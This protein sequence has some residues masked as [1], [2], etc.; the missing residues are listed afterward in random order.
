MFASERRGGSAGVRARA[1]PGERALAAGSVP[2]ARLARTGLAVA[3]AALVLQS[4]AHLVN[5]L[6][7]D[8]RFR[9][10]NADVDGNLLSWVSALATF[11]AASAAL[12]LAA[13]VPPRRRRLVALAAI[14]A[15]FSADEVIGIH[16]N[17]GAAFALVG[18]P[19]VAGI[20]FPVYLPVFALTIWLL[21]TVAAD[22]PA[23]ATTLVLGVAL[24]VAAIG[25]EVLRAGW[26]HVLDRSTSGVA[27]SLEVAVEEGAE[28]A[29]W[30]LIATGLTVAVRAASW[31][32][33]SEPGQERGLI[34]RR[35]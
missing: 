19:D 21:W 6:A 15:F 29:G 10:L 26:V 28:L 27:Y 11:A 8:R 34:P 24:L 31:S 25:A 18:L 16:E 32:A 20:W 17:L 1:W 35:T 23:A 9:H 13:A 12:A 3:L 14:L 7:L 4:A 22:V 2:L 30:I 5:D 33:A